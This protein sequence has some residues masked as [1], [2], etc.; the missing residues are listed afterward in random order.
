MRLPTYQ[1]LDK[2][3]DKI[4][5][6]PLD[7]SHIVTGPPGTGKTV[8]ALYRAKMYEDSGARCRI[9]M[10]SRLL[11]E[12]VSA[13]VNVLDLG[14]RVTTYNSWVWNFYVKTYGE[15]PDQI[16]K[17]VFD[18]QR[19]LPKI[20]SNLP[21]A[22]SKP[23]IIVD[24]GQDLPS[25]FYTVIPFMSDQLTIFADENQR[26]TDRNSTIQEIS[27]NTQIK[28]FFRLTRNYRNTRPIAELSRVFHTG[29]KDYLPALPDKEGRLPVIDS[30]SG[31]DEFVDFL[32]TYEEIYSD[33][34]LGV[35][36]ETISL[37]EEILTKIRDKTQNPVQYYR[38]GQQEYIDFNRQGICLV[39]F[40]SAKGLEFDTVFIPEIQSLSHDPSDPSTLMQM[41]VLISRARDELFLLY[42][43][44]ERPELLEKIPSDLVESRD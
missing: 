39:S 1:E 7:K 12:Y 31:V 24:E 6:L 21:D 2:E 9:L 38:S 44:S 20:L 3:Q 36:T 26:I 43:G 30:T 13:E 8:M 42:S 15:R 41:Y 5:N 29:S 40:K 28:N 16:E 17:Y 11:S 18:W 23:N 22:D 4:Y 35:F 19:I 34:F 27:A 10:L 25:D 33:L 32:I 37:Q 14:A